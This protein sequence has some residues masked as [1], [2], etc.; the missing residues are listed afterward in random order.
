MDS[1]D[2]LQLNCSYFRGG[3]GD[4]TIQLYNQYISIIEAS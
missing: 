4:E 1:G 2:T 3:I